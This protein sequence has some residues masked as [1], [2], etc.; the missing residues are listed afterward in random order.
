MCPGSYL[1]TTQVCGFYV[2]CCTSFCF[3]VGMCGSYLTEERKHLVKI[4]RYL[5]GM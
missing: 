2:V 1:D 4:F 3:E 5:A